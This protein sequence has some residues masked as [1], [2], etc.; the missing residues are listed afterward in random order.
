MRECWIKE[1]D[2]RGIIEESEL[3]WL[4]KVTGSL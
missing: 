3:D 4:H 1:P 2:E